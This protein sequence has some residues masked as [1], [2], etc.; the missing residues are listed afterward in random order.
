MARAL[1]VTPTAQDLAQVAVHMD[2]LSPE[3]KKFRCWLMIQYELETHCVLPVIEH[4]SDT[5]EI[6]LLQLPP[7]LQAILYLSLV[8]RPSDFNA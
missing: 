5:C 6:P 1:A 7:H 2:R 8:H 3:E 4:E